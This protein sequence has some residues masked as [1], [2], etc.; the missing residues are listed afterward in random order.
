M[1]DRNEKRPT[2]D[3]I[4]AAAPF[5]TPLVR[6]WHRWLTAWRSR[7]AYVS[8]HAAFLTPHTFDRVY[9]DNRGNHPTQH[10]R[11]T[12]S[13]V[14]IKGADVLAMGCRD[15]QEAQLWRQRG[16]RSV[17]GID[18]TPRTDAWRRLRQNDPRMCFLA[19]DAR[20]LP[21]ADRTFDIVSSE[22]LLEHVRHPGDAIAEMHRVAKPGGLVY[23][24]FGPL[25]FT[26]GGAHYEG[27]Y[28]HLLQERA[29][30]IDWIKARNRPIETEECL[31][32]YDADMF[33]YWTADQYLHEFRKH[34][35]MR[36]AVFLSPE[37]RRVQRQHPDMWTRLTAT[38]AERDLLVS[39]LA[40]WSRA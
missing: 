8:T 36:S 22:S 37:A 32:Y 33:S 39:G 14:Q 19:A 5:L 25:Y 7:D 24:I 11:T 9:F 20:R 18:Y 40:I 23:S 13:L 26:A 17:T 3:A 35:I 30:F 10:I 4:K 31:S 1:L 27:T 2:R 6:A 21:F 29:M 16:A 34:T 12:R 38:H 28:E 15:G